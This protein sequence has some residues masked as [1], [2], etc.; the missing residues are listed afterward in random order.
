M[1][2]TAAIRTLG[3]AGTKYQRLLD[4]LRSQTIPPSEILVYIAEGYQIPEETVG[5]EKY[6]YVK[7]GMVAQRALQYREVKTEY[8]LFL[9]DDVFLPPTS[10][11][12]LFSSLNDNGLDIISP[13]V[14]YN[15]N[16]SLGNE[17]LMTISGRMR[18][19][20]HEDGWGYKVMR[21]GGYSYLKHPAKSVYRSQTNAGP[22][23]LCKKDDFLSIHYEDEL[24]LDKMPY[25]LGDDQLMFYKMHLSGLK[26]GT[27]YDSGIVHLDAGTTMNDATKEDMLMRSDI[28]FKCVFWYKYI[29]GKS[30]PFLKKMISVVAVA[31]SLSFTL[32]ISLLKLDFHHLTIKAN[33]VKEAVH[34]IKNE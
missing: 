4:S 22:C 18:A 27:I 20:R 7:K 33:S 21:T 29:Y 31:Y 23:F 2:Y 16:R 1:E 10:V 8:I 5:T 14:F 26:L 12:Y 11:E 30:K 13:D 34:F 6:I 3:K 32:L 9:D 24:W 25:A 17:F 15:S 19:R 28:F